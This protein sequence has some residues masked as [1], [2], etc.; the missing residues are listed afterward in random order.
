MPVRGIDGPADG[1]DLGDGGVRIVKGCDGGVDVVDARAEHERLVIGESGDAPSGIHWGVVVRAWLHDVV[2]RLAGVRVGEH[3]VVTED[4]AGVRNVDQA[5]EC[6]GANP[7][8]AGGHTAKYGGKRG[9]PSG[10][11][12][13][14]SGAGDALGAKAFDFVGDFDIGGAAL[15]HVDAEDVAGDADSFDSRCESGGFIVQ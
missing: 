15:E 6:T 14:E 8:M 1:H 9:P 13:T 10:R 2:V 4:A 11:T 5:A 3:V 7:M 12:E